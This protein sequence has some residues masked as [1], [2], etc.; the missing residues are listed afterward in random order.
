M[1]WYGT[2]RTKTRQ[3]PRPLLFLALAR[4]ARGRR[5]LRPRLDPEA[6]YPFLFPILVLSSIHPIL[7]FASRFFPL[8]RGLGVTAKEEGILFSLSTASFCLALLLS[9][10]SETG[11]LR[12]CASE[13]FR[14]LRLP[15]RPSRRLH[16]R[17]LPLP[18]R[19]GGREALQ[20]EKGDRH[21]LARRLAFFGNRGGRDDFPR[22]N[23]LRL[24]LA[25]RHRV[26]PLL[27]HARPRVILRS[28][29]RL[30][31]AATGW[32]G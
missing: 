8:R 10:L 1:S 24:I 15:L 21:R 11:R 25:A 30:S 20:N 29:P 12:G 32:K 7:C 14:G 18:F 3:R 28:K 26:R 17:L 5:L 23:A 16:P 2:P 27:P 6:A 31:F 9:V 4:F 13:A 19:L 22:G